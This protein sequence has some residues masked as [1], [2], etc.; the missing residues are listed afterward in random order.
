MP[1]S[2]PLGDNNY[3]DAPLTVFFRTSAATRIIVAIRRHP[4]TSAAI[5]D[6]CSTSMTMTRCC[7]CDCARG[8]PSSSIDEVSLSIDGVRGTSLLRKFLFRERER[9]AY[10]VE[11]VLEREKETSEKEIEIESIYEIL[12]SVS[13]VSQSSQVCEN[14]F[15]I[16]A[17]TIREIGHNWINEKICCDISHEA[18]EY[19]ITVYCI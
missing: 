19:E 5:I 18:D 10:R 15:V 6:R 14:L 13:S 17:M 2:V 16:F 12:R 4:A 1:T 9:R 3:Y 11:S 7:A 8:K